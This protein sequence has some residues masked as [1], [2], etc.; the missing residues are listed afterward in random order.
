MTVKRVNFYPRT[1]CLHLYCPH[2]FLFPSHPSSPS[3]CA[4]VLAA[5]DTRT[6]DPS[7]TDV[8]NMRRHESTSCT[9]STAPRRSS[10]SSGPYFVGYAFYCI[11]A[12]FTPF[13]AF[14]FK[15]FQTPRSLSVFY[16]S[17]PRSN[18][19]APPSTLCPPSHNTIRALICTTNV[20]ASVCC[21]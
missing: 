6:V 13:R 17:F 8:T 20:T 5:K 18:V 9:T 15:F 19:N 12:H 3:L 2:R 1:L 21:R 7:L 4:S 16:L 11:W 10:L 14:L